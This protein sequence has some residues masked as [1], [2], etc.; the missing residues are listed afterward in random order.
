MIDK[1]E[2]NPLKFDKHIY[3]SVHRGI[4]RAAMRLLEKQNP[5]AAAYYTVSDL[6]VMVEN[7]ASPDQIG[8]RQQGSG[9]HYFIAVSPSGIPSKC[10]SE[11]WYPNGKGAYAPS[12]RT[13][14]ESELDAARN[15]CRSGRQDAGMES[16]SRAAHMLADICCPPHATGLS[17][18]SKYGVYHKRYEG[19][20]AEIF[21]GDTPV[22]EE[23]TAALHWAELAAGEIP[24]AEF[25]EMLS[26]TNPQESFG[27]MNSLFRK[28]ADESARDLHIMLGEDMEAIRAS[29]Q[30][31]VVTAIR[32]VA[33]LM[34]TFP[35]C[36]S[37]ENACTLREACPYRL[38]SP[39]C[40]KSLLNELMYVQFHEDG[41]FSLTSQDNR[42]LV[43]SPLGRV[44]LS[45]QTESPNARF[46]RGYEPHPVIYVGSDMNR[47]LGIKHGKLR[48]YDRRFY[49]YSDSF[50]RKDTE[51]L[52]SE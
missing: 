29:V 15:L 20:A 4:I 32:Y 16:F 25:D 7:A 8:D 11:G 37:Q 2:V 22:S 9:L 1:K 23:E 14:F 21:W 44:I 17:Y 36:I 28:L 13:M 5:T 43:V 30:R 3:P 45:E 10:S 12:P 35:A 46:R 24:Y 52:L 42:C 19:M 27:K 31:R 47:M 50:F 38:V 34:G 49:P 6:M 39:H 33:A 51:L 26:L 41:S 40:D 18:L 48:C